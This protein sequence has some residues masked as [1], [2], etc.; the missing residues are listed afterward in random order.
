VAARRLTLAAAITAAALVAQVVAGFLTNSLALLA[1]AGH[2]LT[3]VVGLGIALFAMRLASRPATLARSYGYYRAEILAA[4]G[5][6]VLLLLVAVFVTYEAI[7]RL[8][9]GADV[10]AAGVLWVGL[11]GLAA[12]V[13]AAALLTPVRD[14][15]LNM[16]GAYL[17]V[18]GDLL[19]SVAVVASAAIVMATN[20]DR[21]DAAASLA[22]AALILPR[23]WSLVREA[24]DVLLESA[25]PGVD[26]AEVRRHILENPSVHD[27]HDLHA[28]TIS[29]GLPV[30]SAHVV[31]KPRA[32]PG[33]AL[34]EICLCLEAT[35]DIE[36]STLQLESEDRRRVEHHGH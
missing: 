12:N 19:G 3:D 36:H 35:F 31:L 9:D 22:I 8:V 10:K 26:L 28:W 32:D 29:T 5:N 25:P 6:G 7:W 20:A 21:V 4:L 16:R 1:D 17:E 14:V 27:V 30:L 18:V 2:L 13:A 24:V 23:V 11:G 34:D 33:A 15:T